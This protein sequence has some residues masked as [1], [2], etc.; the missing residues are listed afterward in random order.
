MINLSIH[1]IYSIYQRHLS[2]HQ[3]RAQARGH[4]AGL[5]VLAGHCP[6]T[7]QARRYVRAMFA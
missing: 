3:T 7:T 1:T 5:L 2:K 4:A 6:D